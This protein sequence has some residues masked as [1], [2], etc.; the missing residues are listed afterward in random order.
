MDAMDGFG[1]PLRMDS[2]L[3]RQ[4][5][6]E[7]GFVDVKEEVIQ[8]PLNRWPSDAH[9]REIGRWFNLG[10]RQ[11][12]QPLSLA[13]LTRG[14]NRTL[15]QVNELVEKIGTEVFSLNQHAYCTL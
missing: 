8:M 5:L 15:A 13:P 10:F 6:E 9:A 7:A 14:H 3:T 11:S 12:I 1:R 4:R 2:N